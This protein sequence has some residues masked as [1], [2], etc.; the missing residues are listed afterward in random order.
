MSTAQLKQF[1]V[2][3]PLIIPP[4]VK[5]YNYCSF[6]LV[7]EEPEGDMMDYCNPNKSL[8]GR[9]SSVSGKSLSI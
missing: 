1:T 6:S 3:L 8:Y 7:E 2:Y 9:C 5:Q 4:S